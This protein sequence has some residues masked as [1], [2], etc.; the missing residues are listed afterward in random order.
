MEHLAIKATTTETTEQGTFV[1][2]ASGW[3]A[4]RDGDVIEKGAFDRTI[5]AWQRSG[6]NL[7]LLFEHSTTVVGALDP[8]SMSNR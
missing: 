2:L 4:D 1:A 7:P 3:S 8:H 5:E 6:K